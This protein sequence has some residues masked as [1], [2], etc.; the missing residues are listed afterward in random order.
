MVEFSMGEVIGNVF[1]FFSKSGIIGL[2]NYVLLGGVLAIFFWIA[3]RLLKYKHKVMII[4]SRGIARP[5][6][7]K[8]DKKDGI[9]KLSVLRA[10]TS[11]SWPKTTI[12]L[13]KS[14][15]FIP[16]IKDNSG[17]LH[18]IRINWD[19]QAVTIEGDPVNLKDIYLDINKINPGLETDNYGYSHI[20]EL[21]FVTKEGKEIVFENFPL[22]QPADTNVMREFIQNNKETIQ[23]YHKPSK[24]EKMAPYAI[25]ATV[26]ILSTVYWMVVAKWH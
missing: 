23:T 3:L 8:E 21:P 22:L 17:Q 13:N 9:H 26:A 18:N 14:R 2:F 12:A 24:W 15:N 4:D 1:P 7:G 11:L 20:S 25:F 5:D 10:K 16:L 6:T 19:T